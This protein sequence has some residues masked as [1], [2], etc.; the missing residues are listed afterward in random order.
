MRKGDQS[1]RKRLPMTRVKIGK[2]ALPVS[3]FSLVLSP[4]PEGG[5]TVTVPALPGCITYGR[6][7]FEA[8]KN[9]REAIEHGEPIP[10]D[11]T[12]STSVLVGSR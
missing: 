7:V 3:Q 5:F 2:K 4:E 10:V 12:I 6:D 1:V 8:R 9:A 11:N